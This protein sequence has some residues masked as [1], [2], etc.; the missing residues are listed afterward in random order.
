MMGKGA[1]LGGERAS[2]GSLPAQEA[3]G[4]GSTLGL[5]KGRPG[6]PS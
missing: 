2:K 4:P 5:G 6:Q 1:G 3:G